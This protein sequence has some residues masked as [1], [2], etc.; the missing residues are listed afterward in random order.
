[1]FVTYKGYDIFVGDCG[2]VVYKG[3]ELV[4]RAVSEKAAMQVI[5]LLV[6][7]EQRTPGDAE[8]EEDGRA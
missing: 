6:E 5:D 1:M 4:A 2:C 7:D 3:G 8:D